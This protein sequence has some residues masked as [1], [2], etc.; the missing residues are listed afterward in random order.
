MAT[1]PGGVKTFTTKVDGAGNKVFA[2]HINDLQD[3]VTA[4]EDG[5]LNGTAPVTSSRV[6]AAA[7]QVAGGSTFTGAVRVAGTSTFEGVATFSTIVHAPSQP[8]FSLT[9]TALL[10]GTAG[11]TTSVSFET[12]VVDRGGF[13]STGS[14]PSL[15]TVPSGSSGLYWLTAQVFA[16]NFNAAMAVYIVKNSSRELGGQGIPTATSGLSILA[17]GPLV[18]EAGD[19]L[20]LEILGPGGSTWSAGAQSGGAVQN[21]LSG[22]KVS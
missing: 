2:S 16:L 4:L 19:V 1:Y 13:H 3:E 15:V 10:T 21:R 17:S 9:S 8:A 5:L 20:R 12:E 7:L 14:N 18:C 6:T 22:V 11:S